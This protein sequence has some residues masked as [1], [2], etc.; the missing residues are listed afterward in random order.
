VIVISSGP[1]SFP[2]PFS[3]PFAAVVSL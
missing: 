1:P 3:L 2:N